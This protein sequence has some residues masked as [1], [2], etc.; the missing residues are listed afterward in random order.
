MNHIAL[1]MLLGDRS[2]YLMLVSALTFATLLMGSSSALFAG[3]MLWTT[4]VLH[5]VRAPIWVADPQVE[6]VTD[7]K[8]LRDT[9]VNRVRSVRGVAW[10]VPLFQGFTQIRMAHGAAQVITLVG[11]DS[12]TLIGAPPA[13]VAGRVQDLLLPHAIILDEDAAKNM[14]RKAGHR[15]GVGEILEINDHEAR[16][17]GIAKTLQS[18]SGGPYVF[19]TYNRAVGDFSPPQRKLLTFV[20]AAPEP[21]LTTDE[22]TRRIQAET[23][24]AAFSK[25]EFMWKTIR[26]WVIYTHI[27]INV[28]SMAVIG[29]FVGMVMSGQTF[30][31]FVVENTRS[32]GALKAMGTSNARL[33][34]MLAIQALTVGGVGFGVG[35]GLVTL[36]GVLADRSGELPFLMTWHIPVGVLVAILVICTVAV[37]RGIQR[38]SKI[39]TASVFR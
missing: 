39:E 6:L 14:S 24:L 17:V 32:L 3:L 20:L 29:F 18:L 21:G 37:D 34:G 19:T 25:S 11:V 1:K 13:L 22:V 28:G 38:L 4:S 30:F 15:V 5:N 31:S 23:G 26:F 35:M 12:D 33:A 36:N 27:P 2:R 9:D 10:A 7:S 16:V 8:P